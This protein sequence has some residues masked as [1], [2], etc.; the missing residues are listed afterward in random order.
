MRNHTLVLLVIVLGLGTL[1]DTADAFSRDWNRYLNSEFDLMF[2]YPGFLNDIEEIGAQMGEQGNDTSAYI[3]NAWVFEKRK[4]TINLSHLDDSV[5]QGIMSVSI[6]DNADGLELIN[7][8]AALAT[9]E[10]ARGGKEAGRID[11]D[12][13]VV[14]SM[15]AIHTRSWID[16]GVEYKRANLY[17]FQ[18]AEHVFTIHICDECMKSVLTTEY[19]DYDSVVDRILRSVKPVD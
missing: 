5:S 6:F 7:W 11:F 14:A 2:E 17:V 18:A 1:S 8:A 12:S 16:V 15:P 3:A 13:L 19:G 9:N 10:L 4:W